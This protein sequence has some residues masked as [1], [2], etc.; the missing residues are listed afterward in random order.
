MRINKF[1]VIDHT[2]HE[3]WR[4]YDHVW[5]DINEAMAFAQKR[6]GETKSVHSVTNY[7]GLKLWFNN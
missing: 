3:K 7:D 2:S 6:M 5:S 4:T 1:Y